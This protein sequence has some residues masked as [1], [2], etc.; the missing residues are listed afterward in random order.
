MYPIFVVVVVVGFFFARVC[1]ATVSALGHAEGSNP[2]LIV[3]FST[4]HLNS[5]VVLVVQ[6][7]GL[8]PYP[9]SPGMV[10]PRRPYRIWWVLTVILNRTVLYCVC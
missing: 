8:G 1:G 4:V 10:Y 5:Y 9:L 2:R 6:C 7:L 3:A